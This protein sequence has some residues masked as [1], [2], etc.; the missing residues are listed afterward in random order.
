MVG[1]FYCGFLDSIEVFDLNSPGEGT[2]LLTIPT[3]RSKDG[4]RGAFFPSYVDSR[5]A[6]QLQGIISSLSF[7]PDFSGLYAAGTFTSS[8]GMFAEN[9]GA[10]VLMYLD[11][12]SG[13][14]SHVSWVP[15]YSEYMVN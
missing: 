12:V 7:C 4:L 2:R 9:T 8:I 5:Y 3:K 13:P 11:G 14:I 6:E 1:R 10:E 15:G